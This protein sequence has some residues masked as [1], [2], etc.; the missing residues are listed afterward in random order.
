MP[1]GILRVFNAALYENECQNP[2]IQQTISLFPEHSTLEGAFRARNMRMKKCSILDQD[3]QQMIRFNL[4]NG[5]TFQ[6]SINADGTVVFFAVVHKKG[7]TLS[8][9]NN[10][11]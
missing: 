7:S 6:I 4:C 10:Y 5:L 11:T 3:V 2:Q 1:H 9:K 8:L